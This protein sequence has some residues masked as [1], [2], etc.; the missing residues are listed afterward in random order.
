MQLCLPAGGLCILLSPHAT[1]PTSHFDW[2]WRNWIHGRS[3]IPQ[4]KRPSA[5]GTPERQLIPPIGRHGSTTRLGVHRP[6]YQTLVLRIWPRSSLAS[7]T[8]RPASF[9]A[10]DIVVTLLVSG[11]LNGEVHYVIDEATAQ[12]VVSALEGKWPEEIDDAVFDKVEG[13]VREYVKGI[14]KNLKTLGIKAK[15]R[16]V[17]PRSPMAG[18]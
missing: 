14:N 5:A 17:A 18:Q 7:E 1:L 3:R 2:G 6:H 16:I 10:G 15:I 12:V 9:R 8:T 11:D 4:R 13:L